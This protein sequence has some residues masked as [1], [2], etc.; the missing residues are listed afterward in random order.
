MNSLEHLEWPE[1]FPLT[2]VDFIFKYMISDNNSNP[3]KR[4]LLNY[5]D[6]RYGNYL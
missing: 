3:I 5:R 2:L 4:S 1:R 6:K